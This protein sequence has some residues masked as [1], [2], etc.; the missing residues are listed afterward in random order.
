MLVNLRRF[1]QTK[2]KVP[3]QFN[4]PPSVPPEKDLGEYIKDTSF[5]V[6]VSERSLSCKIRRAWTQCF[7]EIGPQ[8]KS[9]ATAL[10]ECPRP[11]VS[12]ESVL[13]STGKVLRSN[14]VDL[15]VI[16]H[17]RQDR[18]ASFFNRARRDERVWTSW[19]AH[20]TPARIVEIWREPDAPTV[21]GLLGKAHRQQLAPLGYLI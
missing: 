14:P 10:Q 20:S 15:L 12:Y 18:A 6:A 11:N 8:V 5:C 17:S 16:D 2:P 1:P 3:S 4:K 9:R 7:W 13:K 19:L 21:V